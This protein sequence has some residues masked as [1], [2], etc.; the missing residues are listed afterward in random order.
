MNYNF[1]NICKDFFAK[2]KMSVSGFD[3]AVMR[4]IR[5]YPM[6]VS[7][8]QM[9]FLDTHDVGRFLSF[10]DEDMAKLK[11]AVAFMMCAPG[12]PSVFYGDEK[13]ITG[14]EESDYRQKMPWDS[15]HELEEYYK[16]WIGLRRSSKALS[17]G[18]YRTSDKNGKGIFDL[19]EN[20]I[21]N[22]DA[23]SVYGADGTV[24][25]STLCDF[26]R[27]HRAPDFLADPSEKGV[28]EE[29]KKMMRNM[30]GIWLLWHIFCAS[31]QM[32]K[33]I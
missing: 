12:I 31:I 28:G 15:S 5:R 1:T 20:E 22:K 7:L 19:P 17:R 21:E 24:K 33:L 16:Y 4:M 23:E 30:H 29:E 10:C 32:K 2:G 11:L 14:L 25:H 18:N 9:N 6:Q 26:T 8:A 13:G 3:A 27:L